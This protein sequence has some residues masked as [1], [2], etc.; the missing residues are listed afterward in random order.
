M[1]K[2]YSQ[3]WQRYFVKMLFGEPFI[4]ER[5]PDP[6]RKR[7]A[8][9]AAVALFAAAATMMYVPYYNTYGERLWPPKK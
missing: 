1:T 4:V 2:R 7:K 3:M 6:K 9:G 8:H 5:E